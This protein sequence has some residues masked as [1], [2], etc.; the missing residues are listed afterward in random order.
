[1]IR[2]LLAKSFKNCFY[3]IKY[4]KKHV[5]FGSG[6]ILGGLNTEFEEYNRIGSYSVFSGKM[7]RCS[8]M[9]CR[10]EISATIGRY[11]SIS[12]YVRVIKGMHPSS[13]WV[14]TS[15][16]FF[17][18]ARQCGKSY[19]ETTLFNEISK[20]TKIDNDVWIGY[21]ALLIG[22]VHIG[23]GAIVAAGAVV[24]KDVPP[25]AIVAGVPAKII[26]YRFEKDQ[27]EML[28]KIAWWNKDEDWVLKYA[29]KFKN[30]ETFLKDVIWQ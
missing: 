18:T 22:G 15:P 16:V 27:I 25:Y 14:S 10:C 7:G 26:K 24:T 2:T 8:Y 4:I 11:C 20:E 12:S 30:I 23:N 1:M 17:S 9:G 19:V 5:K 28:E 29:N 3:K 6:V 21:G 13:C